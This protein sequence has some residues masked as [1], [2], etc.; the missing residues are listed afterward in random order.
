MNDKCAAGT[1][2][3]LQSAAAALDIPW[4]SWAGTRSPAS[5]R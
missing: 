1:G 5:G 3:F 4:A 2:R